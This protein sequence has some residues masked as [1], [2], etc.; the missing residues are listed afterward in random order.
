VL[1][2]VGEDEDVPRELLSRPEHNSPRDGLIGCRIGRLGRWQRKMREEDVI[3][4]ILDGYVDRR[5]C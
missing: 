2:S 1:L 4:V 3:R 5:V